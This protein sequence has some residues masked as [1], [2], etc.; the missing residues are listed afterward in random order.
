MVEAIGVHD[1]IN[2]R[3]VQVVVEVAHWGRHRLCGNRP[4]PEENQSDPHALE[5][6]KEPII[7]LIYGDFVRLRLYDRTHKI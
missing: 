1:D 2:S 5:P 7:F 3:H 6:L 4:H